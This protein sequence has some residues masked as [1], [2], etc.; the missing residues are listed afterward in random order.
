MDSGVD[1]ESLAH[2]QEQMDK[3][4]PK[5]A[6]EHLFF[7]DAKLECILRALRQSNPSEIYSFS[8]EITNS[9]NQEI[10][11]HKSYEL[12]PFFFATLGLSKKSSL[13]LMMD[14]DWNSMESLR[15]NP[16][17]TPTPLFHHWAIAPRCFNS[18]LDQVGV[19]GIQL[20]AAT[21]EAVLCGKLS[22]DVRWG[23]SVTLIGCKMYDYH[24]SI[25]AMML[26]DLLR[27]KNGIPISLDCNQKRVIL[28][29][30]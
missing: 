18:R 3:K 12:G 5:V 7:L 28:S 4:H 20:V 14:K 17:P 9:E 2:Q 23:V 10:H 22:N 11:L 26:G 6:W 15:T 25:A 1:I 27:V 13:V 19:P 29:P 30:L 24:E 8:M 16:T 21:V